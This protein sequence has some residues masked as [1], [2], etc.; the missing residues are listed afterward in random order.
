MPS[1]DLTLK[2]LTAGDK[3][4]PGRQHRSYDAAGDVKYHSLQSVQVGFLMTNRNEWLAIAFTNT[5]QPDAGAVDWSQELR[6]IDQDV[7]ICHDCS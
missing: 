3:T 2:R 1:L 7:E 4:L 5:G 6:S